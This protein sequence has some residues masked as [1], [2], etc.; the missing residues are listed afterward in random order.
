ML[1]GIPTKISLLF[2][3]QNP[4]HLG[5]VFRALSE[6]ER[7]WWAMHEGKF[8]RRTAGAVTRFVKRGSSL[9]NPHMNKSSRL[10]RRMTTRHAAAAASMV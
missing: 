4:G 9:S 2:R 5:S 8:A 10:H 3:I 6:D 7:I 1:T